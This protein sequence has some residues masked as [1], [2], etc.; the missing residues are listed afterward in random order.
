MSLLAIALGGACGACLRAAIMGA[1][2]A[3]STHGLAAVNVLGSF[4]FGVIAGGV[5]PALHPLLL[6]GLCGALTTFSTFAHSAVEL[7]RAG[8]LGAWAWMTVLNLVGSLAGLAAGAT[9][10]GP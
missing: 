9:L 1:V 8:R 6:T 10:A 2:A 4:F 3:Y 5:D 7:L